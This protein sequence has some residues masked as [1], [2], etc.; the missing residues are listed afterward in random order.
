MANVSYTELMRVLQKTGAPMGDSSAMDAA[1]PALRD[2]VSQNVQPDRSRSSGFKSSYMDQIHKIA[3]MDQKLGNLYSDPT[4]ELYME[5]PLQREKAMSGARNTYQNAA[6]DLGNESNKAYNDETREAESTIDDAVSLYKQLTA[7]QKREEAELKKLQK[8][9]DKASKKSG[10]G[11]SK[12][13]AQKVADSLSRSEETKNQRLDLAGIHNNEAANI[14][15]NA[16]KAFQDTW[17]RDR[18]EASKSW[19]SKEPGKDFEED[20][21]EGSLKKAVEEWKKKYK[22]PAKKK[23]STGLFK[24][25][26]ETT[27]EDIF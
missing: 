8:E 26:K 17:I 1:S 13:L 21:N 24:E 19:N 18:A 12:D 27:P 2:S 6:N 14:F 20:Y 23:A 7:Q 3:Q 5:N 10:S 22:A 9:A 25:K 16:P 4:S 15:F 11:K